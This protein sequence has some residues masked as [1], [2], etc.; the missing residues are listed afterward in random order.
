M[1]HM[2]SNILI[3]NAFSTFESATT[4]LIK[5]SP[6]Y[7][8]MSKFGL[9][10][11]EPQFLVSSFYRFLEVATFEPTISFLNTLTVTV[12]NRRQIIEVF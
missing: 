6:S 1:M 11:L 3:K 12:L 9:V 7:W 4:S 5:L 2:R 10:D 8:M